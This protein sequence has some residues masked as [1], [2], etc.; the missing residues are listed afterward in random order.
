M[1]AQGK[2]SGVGQERGARLRFFST[3]SLFTDVEAAVASV[4]DV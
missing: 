4:G 2:W 3:D 1:V